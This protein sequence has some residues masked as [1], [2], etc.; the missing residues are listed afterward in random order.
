[1]AG[2]LVRGIR[3][4]FEHHMSIED[5]IS[6]LQPKLSTIPG[7]RVFLQNPP[8]IRIGGQVT[9]SQYQFTLVS[10]QTENLYENAQTF[11]AKMAELPGLTN[12]TTDLQIRNPQA[13]VIVDRD[14]AS[15][16]GVTPQAVED[17]LYS[18]YGQRQAST[19]YAPNNEYFVILQVQD[20]YQ[21]DP[22][23]LSQLY[24]RSSGGPT[25]PAERRLPLHQGPRPAHDQPYG[26]ASVG[27]T[28]V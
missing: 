2:S 9:K 17:A 8:S 24:I 16:L 10:P 20:R 4:L 7:V 23:M 15:A 27:D 19:I 1:M 14:K 6:E 3:P 12:V 26:P 18:A 22:A 21:S 25:R 5:I 28:L 11:A 13:N